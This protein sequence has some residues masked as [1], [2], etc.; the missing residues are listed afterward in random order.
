MCLNVLFS[1]VILSPYVAF[2][3]NKK[4]M[5][6]SSIITI[7]VEPPTGGVGL[8]VW[9]AAL[10]LLQTVEFDEI[11]DTIKKIYSALSKVKGVEYTGA[12]KV[13]HLINRKLFVMWDSYIRKGYGLKSN[14]AEGIKDHSELF[15]PEVDPLLNQCARV[16]SYPLLLFHVFTSLSII[17]GTIQIWNVPSIVDC[18]QQNLSRVRSADELS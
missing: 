15:L 7:T 17:V 14:D 9:R 2:P 1:I 18:R 3:F 16:E 12:S 13:M 5:Y 10:I 4:R 11:K 8:G 6:Y